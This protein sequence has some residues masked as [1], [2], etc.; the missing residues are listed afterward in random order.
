MTTHL[1]TLHSVIA[2]GLKLHHEQLNSYN[3]THVKTTVKI[4]TV[5]G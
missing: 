1:A 5:P 3:W 2:S 4:R